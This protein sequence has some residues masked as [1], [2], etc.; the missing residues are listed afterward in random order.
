MK[1]TLSA[2]LIVILVLA[3]LTVAGLLAYQHFAGQTTDGPVMENP[4]AP[5]LELLNAG[6]MSEDGVWSAH[7][8]GIEGNT[9]DLSYRQELVYS[10]DFTFDFN[11]DDPNVKTELQFYDTQFESEDGSVC[12]TMES[13]YVEKCRMYL[14]ITISKDG[15]DSVRQ[16]AVL[17]RAEYGKSQPGELESEE[18]REVSEMAELVAFSWHQSA[19]SYD[20]C[21]QFQI[22]TTEQDLSDPRLYCRYADPQTHEPVE[23]GNDAAIGFQGYGLGGTKRAEGETWLPVPLKRWEELADFLRKVELS[24]YRAPLP[25][26]LDATSSIIAVTWRDGGEEFTNRYGGGTSAHDLLELLQDIAREAYSQKSGQN[27]PA[28]EGSWT[29][30]CGQTG[31]T[32]RFCPEC[33]QP[34]DEGDMQ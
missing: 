19:M 16:Q 4:A 12:S 8:G 23:I 5:M 34:F 3:V 1:K 31:N 11:G 26:L 9:F 28:P 6:W 2:I 20:G 22:K 7:I 29:C 32:G 13:L 14:D 10:G 15:G 18:I 30:S 27:Q 25:G 17:D 21:F 33:G 24:A